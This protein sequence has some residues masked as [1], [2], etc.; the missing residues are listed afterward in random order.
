[1]TSPWL[2]AALAMFIWWF[3]TGVI[4][5]VVRWADRQGSVHGRALLGATP[6]L[7]LGAG[8]V[9][10]SLNSNGWAAFTPDSW[11]PLRSGAGSRWP[12]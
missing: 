12:F 2:A 10:A 7:A 4:L 1:M 9:I 3:A 8:G 6:L 11:A 5:L